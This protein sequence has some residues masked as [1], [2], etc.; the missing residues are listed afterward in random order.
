MS[1]LN[2]LKVGLASDQYGTEV[3][4]RIGNVSGSAAAVTIGGTTAAITA[5]NIAVGGGTTA[6]IGFFGSA[7]TT[8]PTGVTLNNVTSIAAALANLGLIGTTAP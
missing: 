4:N 1:L 5:P 3:H 6:S 2:W 8:K 7:V